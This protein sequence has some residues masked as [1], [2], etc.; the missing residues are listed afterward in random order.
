MSVSRQPTGLLAQSS[1]SLL[2]SIVPP[3]TS[4]LLSPL[5][6]CKRDWVGRLR[7]AIDSTRPVVQQRRKRT[8]HRDGVPL[9]SCNTGLAQS[10]KEKRRSL[11]LL[12]HLL[13]VSQTVPS[14]I[15]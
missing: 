3:P 13:S 2:N 9:S 14:T 12:P 4:P 6:S 10:E 15:R 7:L 5:L 8:R 11:Y 1:F